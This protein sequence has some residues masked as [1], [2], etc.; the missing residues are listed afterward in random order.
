MPARATRPLDKVGPGE[1][2]MKSK[3]T[4]NGKA[5]LRRKPSSNR[6]GENPPYGMSGGDWGNMGIMPRASQSYSTRHG[7]SQPQA[8][9]SNF[10]FESLEHAAQARRQRRRGRRPARPPGNRRRLSRRSAATGLAAK[11]LGLRSQPNP[12]LLRAVRKTSQFPARRRNKA[13]RE[14]VSVWVS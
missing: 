8:F 12:P 4:G 1:S 5:R 7:R 11:F 2:E 13:N 3:Q 6:I 14:T 10:T 9:A